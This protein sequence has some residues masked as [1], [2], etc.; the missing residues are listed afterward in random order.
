MEL[1]VFV[2]PG[3]G[4]NSYIL[5]SKGEAIIVDPQRDVWRFLDYAR[6]KGLSIRYVLET[7]VHNDYVSGALELREATGADI[8]APR[9][10]NYQFPHRAV[11]EGD[12]VQLGSLR[13]VV[14]DTPGHTPEHVSYLVFQGEAGTPSMVFTGGSLLVGNAGRSDLLGPQMTEQLARA[15]FRS[16]RRLAELPDATQVLPTH[17][18]GSFCVV[19][20]PGEGNTSTIGR[21]RHSNTALAALDEASFLQAHLADLPAFPAYYAYM[22][23]I[24]RRGP[25]VLGRL[26]RP[27]AL[28][29]GEVAQ[30]MERGA[31]VVD[32]R[33]ANHFARAHIPGSVNIELGNSF[34]NYV[35][36]VL[37]FNQPVV[38]VLPRPEEASLEMAVTALVRIGYESIEGYLAG[39]VEAWA[40]KGRPLASYKMASLKDLCRA[41][42]KG[43]GR[44]LDVRQEVEWRAEHI[45]QSIHIFLGDLP[46]RLDQIPRDREVWAICSTGYRASI[47]AS[48][49]DR[50]GI[51][52]RLV[53][54]G[55][56]SQW[57]EQCSPAETSAGASQGPT[58]P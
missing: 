16:L 1:Q 13:V 33:R 26:P 5:S 4:D 55:G 43:N 57:L 39:G 2:T 19:G 18:A 25:G 3:L 21:E 31:W 50:A 28:A 41:Y 46:R 27:P 45:P 35:G 44:V 48:L 24:N 12:E 54:P 34:A 10:G 40:S 51:P 58:Q 9:R 52:V 17:G 56:V 30:R 53:R 15:Q 49:L 22:A 38:L 42:S 14:M 6:A 36:W 32:A 11:G 20:G 37:P 47:A 23:P 7:H 29:T 8:V